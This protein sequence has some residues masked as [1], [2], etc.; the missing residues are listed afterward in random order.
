MNQ[1]TN[2]PLLSEGLADSR[3]ASLPVN[4]SSALADPMDEGAEDQRRPI[5]GWKNF[6]VSRDGVVYSKGRP[7]KGCIQG[8]GYKGVS[9]TEKRNNGRRKTALIHRLVLEAFSDEPSNGRECAHGD[10]N[11]L[12]NHISNL[13]WATR[14]ENSDD[15]VK[16]NA[17]LKGEEQ[18]R[19][20][21][22]TKHAI[23]AIRWI[24]QGIGPSE[25]GRRL[26]VHHQTIRDIKKGVTWKHI[27]R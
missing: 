9:L 20:K 19:S 12:N 25:I 7:M 15:A 6:E 23:L 5:K 17:Y 16:H 3:G 11:K 2:T 24:S 1:K 26:G 10:G 8:N 14:K 21:L 22:C 13:R 27:P 18:P 4:G